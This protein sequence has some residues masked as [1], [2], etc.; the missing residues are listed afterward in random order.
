MAGRLLKRTVNITTTGAAGSAT[1]SSTTKMPFDGELY[2]VKA[3]YHAS[4][5]NTADLT[6]STPDAGSAA[7]VIHFED[8]STTDA[9]YHPRVPATKA[10]DGT[11]ITDGHLPVLI[12]KGATITCALGGADALTNAVVLT[13]M[14]KTLSD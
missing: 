13:L 6:I 2:S 9:R 14:F 11:A 8:N 12:Q 7:G 5:P 1:G 10:A 3:D 4:T